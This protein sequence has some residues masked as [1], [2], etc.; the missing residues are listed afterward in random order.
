[1]R[2]LE[3]FAMIRGND[4]STHLVR[5]TERDSEENYYKCT[6]P[7]MFIVLSD[8][9]VCWFICLLALGRATIVDQ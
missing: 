5:V 6:D 9:F 3:K 4:D 8:M 7:L 1:M 2:L